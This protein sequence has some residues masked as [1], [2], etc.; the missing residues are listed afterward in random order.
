MSNQHKTERTGAQDFRNK[1]GELGEDFS[2]MATMA[3][4]AGRDQIGKLSNAV[5]KNYNDAKD[6]LGKWEDSM[7][8]YVRKH[9]MKS[10]L[11]AAGA[12]AVLCVLWRHR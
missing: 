9:P 3:A 2:E 12:G 1:A 8:A 5:T 11:M 7:E 4:D 6:H 10:L